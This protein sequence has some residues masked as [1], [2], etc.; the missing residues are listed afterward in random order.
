MHATTGVT[1]VAFGYDSQGR[2]STITD[3]LGNL[4]TVHRSAAGVL[5]S[6]PGFVVAAL[7]LAAPDD[8]SVGGRQ[9]AEAADRDGAV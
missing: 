3:G 6:R 8:I 9:H 2:V 1:L 5:Q 4:T 7:K